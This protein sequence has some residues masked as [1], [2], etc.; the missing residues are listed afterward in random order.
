MQDEVTQP[1]EGDVPKK[2]VVM[3]R[4]VTL[5]VAVCLLCLSCYSGAVM[6][7]QKTNE[8]KPLLSSLSKEELYIF[9]LENGVHFPTDKMPREDSEDMTV[10]FSYVRA[11]EENP[12]IPSGLNY[13]EAALQFE[14]IR[15]AVISYYGWEN[16]QLEFGSGSRYSLQY[17]TVYDDTEN[18]NQN[19][20]GYVLNKPDDETSPG[21][22]SNGAYNH[23]AGID[24]AAILVKNDL[25]S[26]EF[27]YSCVRILTYNPGY[28]YGL[29]AIRKDTTMDYQSFNDFHVARWMG[30]GWNH[31][32]GT[33][34]VLRF[35]NSPTNS[36]L[37]Y[38]ECYQY[39]TA[40]D[41]TVS[42]DSNLRF[43]QFKMYHGTASVQYTG[44]H[45]HSGSYHYYRIANVCSDCGTI[46]S[47]E[48]QMVPC[49][50]PPCILPFSSTPG[51]IE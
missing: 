31:K 34:A 3:K 44:E 39:G 8:D 27:N 29:I 26:S 2:E 43:I 41:W 17:S 13:Y 7:E 1:Q 20:Y 18:L 6:A 28:S 33:T 10:I 15:A 9:L 11:L 47:Y 48:W 22:Y 35:I 42:Y 37:W 49:S 24:S 46:L 19:C 25:K 5:I 51:D 45:Y 38:N 21:D 40:Y 23:M 50:G 14:E 12:F 36:E 4:I 16:R 32:P 30:T